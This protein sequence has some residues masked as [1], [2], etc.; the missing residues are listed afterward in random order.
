MWS[1]GE[2]GLL[3]EETQTRIY[4]H[5]NLFSHVVGQIDL[6][7]N[8][9][10]G[11]E[12]YFNK[13]LKT[14]GDKP[15]NLSLDINL[16]YLIRDELLNSISNFNAKGA[17]SVL[18]DIDTGEVLSLISLPDYDLNVRQ[19]I[20]DENFMNKITKGVFE[21]GSIFK[22]FTI[23]LA[24]ENKLFSPDT[25]IKD[26]PNEIKCSKYTITEHDELPS[27]LT[28]RD[29]LIRS[30]NIGTIKIAKQIGKINLK[31]F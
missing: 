20:K 23:T 3:F 28:L 17:A 4:P 10:S 13:D 29:I 31:N 22:T 8:G 14:N 9:I 6:D 1:L 15:L 16:Q 5:K 25:V 7:N 26:I 27:S 18:M 12:K 21:L 19:E 24:L 11:V 30:S 2:K